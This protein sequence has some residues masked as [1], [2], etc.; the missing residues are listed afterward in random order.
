[1]VV[2]YVVMAIG[3]VYDNYQPGQKFLVGGL[4][5]MLAY[6]VQFTGGFQDMAWL[7]AMVIGTYADFSSSDTLR[8]EQ[9]IKL[10][11]VMVDKNGWTEISLNNVNYIH[12]AEEAHNFVL[13]DVD[14][15]VKNGQ[16]IALIGASG[17]GK[18]TFMKLMRGLYTPQS[19]SVMLDDTEIGWE[20]LEQLVLFLPQ[21]AE[22]FHDSI[23]YNLCL[24]LEIDVSRIEMACKMT[25]FD[26]VIE[27]LPHGLHTVIN[28]RGGNLSGGE[29]QLLAITRCILLDST[30]PLLLFDEPT[31]SIDPSGEALLLRNIFNHYSDKSVI[32]S[33]HRHYLLPMF[34]YVYIMGEGQVIWKGT[35]QKMLLDESV[36]KYVNQSYTN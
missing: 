14:F 28:Q 6:A 27:R 10:T 35:Y 4:V 31:S 25:L 11:S 18:T 15:K 20:Q 8:A 26:R 23:L 5:A 1:V 12:S 24:G 34:D 36:S 3:Y 7:Y 17:S 33:L 22:V 2:I 29:R 9:E 13:A 32:F 21:E 16:K 19:G 30:S